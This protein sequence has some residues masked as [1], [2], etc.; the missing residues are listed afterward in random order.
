MKVFAKMSSSQICAG[1]LFCLSMLIMLG[2]SQPTPDKEKLLNELSQELVE[3]DGSI[4]RAVIDYLY[5]K[6]LFN[7][8]RAQAGAAEIQQGKRS[9]WKQCAFNAVSCFGQK[10]EGPRFNFVADNNVHGRWDFLA[11]LFRFRK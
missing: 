7:R 3:D 10:R 4:D 5:A 11:N 6:Q 2:M 8:L 1:V 9:Y